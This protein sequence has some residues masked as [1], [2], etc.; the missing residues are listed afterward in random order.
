MHLRYVCILQIPVVKFIFHLL[1]NLEEEDEEDDEDDNDDDDEES[2]SHDDEEEVELEMDVPQE[3][4]SPV[5]INIRLVQG[6]G[7]R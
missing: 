7:V 3:R 4:N 6:H 5:D 1:Q 2:E